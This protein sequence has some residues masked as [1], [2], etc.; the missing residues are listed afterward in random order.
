[1]TE[2]G[3]KIILQENTQE[4]MTAQVRTDEVKRSFKR[5]HQICEEFHK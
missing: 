4:I 3:M 1:M 5:S 2:R